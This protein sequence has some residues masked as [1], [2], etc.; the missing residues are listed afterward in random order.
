MKQI[1]AT[2][3]SIG[4]CLSLAFCVAGCREARQTL[5]AAS[6]PKPA[7]ADTQA[8]ED[9]H[10]GHEHAAALPRDLSS[11][12]AALKD[13]Y[14]AIKAAF[15][16]GDTEKAHEPLHDVGGVLEAL[17]ELAKAAGLAGA[18]AE[19]LTQSVDKMFEA[20]GTIDAALHDGKPADYKA[21]AGV[22]DENMAAISSVP[23]KGPP[24]EK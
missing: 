6:D 21:V 1:V 13:H 23:V 9:A 19:K 10:A 15:E 22:L 5:P 20:Y 24:G 4:L 18:D 3:I 17:P 8:D 11:G 12:I 16:Q 14:E 2:I 7:S